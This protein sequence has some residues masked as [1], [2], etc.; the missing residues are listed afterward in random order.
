MFITGGKSIVDVIHY[1]YYSADSFVSDMNTLCLSQSLTRLYSRRV[2]ISGIHQHIGFMAIIFSAH[3]SG[4]C[5]TGKMASHA[6]FRG[7]M[8]APKGRRNTYHQAT[9]KPMGQPINQRT[10]NQSKAH[11][12][13]GQRPPRPSPWPSPSPAP[14]VSGQKVGVL[15]EKSVYTINIL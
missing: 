3:V 12:R 5:T 10:R 7:S 13:P 11:N 15:K 1:D 4:N 14:I 6:D 9:K 2:V 8:Q